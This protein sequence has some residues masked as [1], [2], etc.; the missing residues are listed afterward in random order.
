MR[1]F[2]TCLGIFDVCP[3]CPPIS[4]LLDRHRT[5]TSLYVIGFESDGDLLA[6]IYKYIYILLLLS[7]YVW[8]HTIVLFVW[9]LFSHILIGKWVTP[10]SNPSHIRLSADTHPSQHNAKQVDMVDTPNNIHYTITTITNLERIRYA[11]R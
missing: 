9:Y 2:L 11:R 10:Y 4:Q 8:A 1:Y 6:Y 5:G 7:L 3:A